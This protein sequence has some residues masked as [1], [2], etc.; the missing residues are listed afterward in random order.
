MELPVLLTIISVL[1]SSLPW[2]LH[3]EDQDLIDAPDLTS[4]DAATE[5][6]SG[7]TTAT[8]SFELVTTTLGTDTSSAY[9]F[10]ASTTSE[11]LL[12]PQ[13]STAPSLQTERTTAAATESTTPV[14]LTTTSKTLLMA[15]TTAQQETTTSY[16]LD[17]TPAPVDQ[18]TSPSPITPSPTA[19]GII[20]PAPPSTPAMVETASASATP[21]YTL[22]VTTTAEPINTIPTVALFPYPTPG[23]PTSSSP[24]FPEMTTSKSTTDTSGTDTSGTSTIRDP[25]LV[26]GLNPVE[27]PGNQSD[28]PVW[29]WVVVAALFAVLASVACIALLI[30]HRKQKRESGLGHNG[31]NGRSQRKK[32]KKGEEDAWAGPVL[33]DGTEKDEGNRYNVDEEDDKDDGPVDGTQPMLSTF[34]PSEDEEKSIGADGTKEAKKWEEQSPLLYIDEDV[35]DE[36]DEETPA[37]Q[38]PAAPSQEEQ[39]TGRTQA[40]GSE[41]QKKGEAIAETCETLN[42]AVAFCQTTAV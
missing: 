35:E 30:K 13:T 12:V 7:A 18:G 11:A 27:E 20:P 10:I 21:E 40:E 16:V 22:A 2:Q 8:L 19:A 42:G 6:A 37:N 5:V 34:T 4:D 1:L 24:P 25:A 29:L 28:K 3:A 33:M 23:I 31:M 15:P 38:R 26:G 41:A 9:T 39:G 32:R 36:V 17:T 14:L